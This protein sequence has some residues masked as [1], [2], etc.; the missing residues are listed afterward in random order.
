MLTIVTES[1]SRASA[2]FLIGVYPICIALAATYLDQVTLDLDLE[3]ILFQFDESATTTIQIEWLTE[4]DDLDRTL[5]YVRYDLT[6][7]HEV[8]MIGLDVAL[9]DC[10]FLYRN[11]TSPI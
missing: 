8:S 7:V 2:S 9:P 5:G 6:T 11:H 1:E 3:G 4:R 10:S